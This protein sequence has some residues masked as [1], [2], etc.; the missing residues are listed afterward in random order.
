MK[1]NMQA[2]LSTLLK[3]LNLGMEVEL[4][5]GHIM[6]WSEEHDAPGFLLKRYRGDESEDVIMQIGSETS[7]SWLISH[8]RG[9]TEEKFL[10]FASDVALNEIKVKR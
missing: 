8:A 7:W 1:P 4:E 10:S 9:M 3:G 5:T 2:K 6:V